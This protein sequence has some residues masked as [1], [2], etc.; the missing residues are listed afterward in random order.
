MSPINLH[1][2]EAIKALQMRVAG[3]LDYFLEHADARSSL[4]G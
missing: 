1:Q 2:F 4:S 3:T